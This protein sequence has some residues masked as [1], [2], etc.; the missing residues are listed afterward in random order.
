MGVADY[1]I[2]LLAIDGEEISEQLR[3]RIE[4]MPQGEFKHRTAGNLKITEAH[5]A[6]LADWINQY[7]DKVSVDFDHS[8]AQ[9]QGSLAAG[10]FIRGSAS[11][12]PSTADASKLSLYADVQWTPRGA[13]AIRTGE[14]RFISPEWNFRWRDNTGKWHETPRLFAAALT[15]RPFFEEMGPVH[16]CDQ[17]L[18]GLLAQAPGGDD[19]SAAKEEETMSLKAIAESLGLAADAA[20]DVVLAKLREQSEERDALKTQVEELSHKKEDAPELEELR[21]SAEAGRKASEELDR[22]RRDALIEGA[23]RERKINPAQREHYEAIWAADPDSLQKLF[24][25]MSAGSFEPLGSEGDPD[26][27]KTKPLRLAASTA[28]DHG[29]L[30]GFNPPSAVPVM[31]QDMPV[32]S[33][34]AEIHKAALEL[35]DGDKKLLSYTEEEYMTAVIAAA[36]KKGIRL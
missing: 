28:G 23:I 5:L 13:E 2:G 16:L 3:S 19:V 20:E 33:D 32:D 22:M 8:F 14:Y 4:V 11:L 26:A 36:D 9:G 29:A 27:T 1:V 24:A 17:G 25:S 18:H 30:Y 15:N 12:E 10:W 7:G 35:L 31:G 34:T 6:G 21:A